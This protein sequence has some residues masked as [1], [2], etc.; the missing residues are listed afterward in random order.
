MDSKGV[1]AWDLGNL[2][3]LAIGPLQRLLFTVNPEG[4]KLAAYANKATDRTGIIS[5]DFFGKNLLAGS[6]YSFFADFTD[7]LI[8]CLESFALLIGLFW[9]LHHDEL[10]VAIGL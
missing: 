9:Q 1:G 6:S 7:V 3:S 10:A 2:V 8:A 5:G 4:T